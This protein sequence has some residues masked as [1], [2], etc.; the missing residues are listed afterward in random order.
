MFWHFFLISISTFV[1][2]QRTCWTLI[3]QCSLQYDQIV[4]FR[5]S[6]K[7]P[8]QTLAKALSTASGPTY[9][10]NSKLLVSFY[11]TMVK[12]HK[13]SFTYTGNI[14]SQYVL[15]AFPSYGKT[16][17]WSG[18]VSR[19]TSV[20]RWLVM[21]CELFLNNAVFEAPVIAF[22]LDTVWYRFHHLSL[23]KEPST[24]CNQKINSRLLLVGQIVQIALITV[25]PST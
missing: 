19:Y 25:L 13:L 5:T 14:N 3:G 15:G 22:C 12:F 16:K 17:F 2:K 9:R 1:L 21:V 20:L 8:F 6:D 18:V 10:N 23:C 7:F 24:C 4:Y 11:R